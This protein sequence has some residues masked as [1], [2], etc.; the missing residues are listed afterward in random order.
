MTEQVDWNRLWQKCRQERTWQGKT[1]ADWNRRAAGFARRN[2]ASQYVTD[3]ISR[4]S[5]RPDMTVLDF[6]SGPGTLAIPLARKVRSVTAVDFS[7]E[8]LDRLAARCQR[9][10]VDNIKI[11]NG[12]WTDDWAGLGIGTYDLVIASRSLSVDD[13]GA[14]LV[15]LNRSAKEQVIIGDRVGSGPFDPALFRAVGREFVPGPDYIYT[16]NILYQ[17]G[18]Y[19]KV[20]FIDI[21][22]PKAYGSREEAQDSC[23][24]ML[25]Q[26]TPDEQVALHRYF[27]QILTE[28]QDGT[29]SMSGHH[30]SK[31]AVISFAPV[32]LG[33]TS[34]GPH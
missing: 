5:L 32:S 9:E 24:W 4:L 26:L 22:E 7:S 18:I 3:F 2:K 19:A 13:L 34:E 11:V 10:G 33:A 29:W 27:D 14:A 23:V 1:Q 17:M 25:D 16:V 12:S 28:N 31:W 20:D 8:M 30:G 6:G 15:K 21:L